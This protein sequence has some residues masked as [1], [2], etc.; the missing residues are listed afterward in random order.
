MVGIVTL[1]PWGIHDCRNKNTGECQ[2]SVS[3]QAK[4]FTALLPYA[5]YDAVE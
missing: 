4:R 1:T 3:N 2:Q 5:E